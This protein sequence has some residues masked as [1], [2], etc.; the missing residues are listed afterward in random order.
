M[1][2]VHGWSAGGLA[3]GI[4]ICKNWIKKKSSGAQALR[5][6]SQRAPKAPTP[7]KR[8]FFEKPPQLHVSYPPIMASSSKYCSTA[9]RTGRGG[10]ELPALLKCMTCLVPGVSSRSSA[11][12]RS[13]ED[14]KAGLRSP[15]RQRSKTPE[16]CLERV[17]P[18]VDQVF[19]R[20][21]PAPCKSFWSAA[22]AQWGKPFGSDLNRSC[23]RELRCVRQNP[24]ELSQ[25]L[26]QPLL[27]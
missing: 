1:S 21:E 14:G 23:P 5:Q 16:S 7:S 2:A 24:F 8:P 15:G 10:S 25:H 18:I 11:R 19:S 27:G 22:V 26:Q 17:L 9:L 20:R 12:G 4:D 3:A 6:G 13:A